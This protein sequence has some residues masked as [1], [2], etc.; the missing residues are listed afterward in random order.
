MAAVVVGCQG[1]ASALTGRLGGGSRA[2]VACC[3]GVLPGAQ[4]A[5]RGRPQVEAEVPAERRRRKREKK[6]ERKKR[7]KGKI[8]K[9]K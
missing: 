6:E 8:E 1:V 5:S 9:K 2:G 3:T 4:L 7:E